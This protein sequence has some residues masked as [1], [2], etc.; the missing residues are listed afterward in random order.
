MVRVFFVSLSLSL[1]ASGGQFS[2]QGQGKGREMKTRIVDKNGVKLEVSVSAKNVAGTE[3][4]CKV[5]L[6][7]NSGEVFDYEHKR[8]SNYRQFEVVVR[9][10]EGQVVPYTAFGR[11]ALGGEMVDGSSVIKQFAKGNVLSH[12]YNLSRLFDLTI[13][14]KYSVSVKR[15][16]NEDKQKKDQFSIELSGFEFDVSE[17]A[18]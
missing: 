18:N 12:Q 9:N 14:G 8:K 13:P 17:P 10:P 4:L 3:I 5:S 11:F 15:V 2:A 16:L 7:N 1:A 6:L